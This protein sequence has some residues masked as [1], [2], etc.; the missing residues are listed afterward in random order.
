MS[1]M[2]AEAAVLAGHAGGVLREAIMADD[3]PKPETNSRLGRRGMLVALLGAVTSGWPASGFGQ[4]YYGPP[5]YGGPAPM[6]RKIPK[7]VA[8]YQYRPNDGMSCEFCW[9]YSGGPNVATARS[10]TGRLRLMVGAATSGR[11]SITVTGI[12]LPE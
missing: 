1:F 8:E 7:V 2:K 4:G 5:P 6:P 11:Y 12:V 3:K 10:W 9:H